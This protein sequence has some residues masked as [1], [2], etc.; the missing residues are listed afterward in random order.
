MCLECCAC[1]EGLGMFL[2][3]RI[4]V[5]TKCGEIRGTLRAFGEIFL[6]VEEENPKVDLTVIQCGKVCS[7]RL[8][9]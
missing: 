7:I 6:E 2:D 5:S 1:P 9:G 4:V 3:R 8:L